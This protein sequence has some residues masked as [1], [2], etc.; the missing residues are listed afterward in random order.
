MASFLDD[1]LRAT[2]HAGLD[3][4]DLTDEGVE[5]PSANENRSAEN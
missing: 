2:G 3:V 5:H 1:L 4:S